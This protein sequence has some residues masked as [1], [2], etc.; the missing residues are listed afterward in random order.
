MASNEHGLSGDGLFGNNLTCP[1][2][3]MFIVLIPSNVRHGQ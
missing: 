1:S 2:R 3:I